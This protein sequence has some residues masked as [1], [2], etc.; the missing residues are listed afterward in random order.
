MVRKPASRYVTIKKKPAKKKTERQPGWFWSPALSA[1]GGLAGGAVGAYVGGPT[2]AS[3]GG[4][5]GK[6][7]GSAAGSKVAQLVGFGDYQ[8]RYPIVHNTILYNTGPQF[9]DRRDSMAGSVR[10]RH[11][12]FIADVVSSPNP[13]TFQLTS[14]PIV[15]SLATSFPWLSQISNAFEEFRFHGLVFEYVTSSGS[16]SST[17][18]LGTV[19]G[20]CRYNS[21]SAPYSNKQQMEASLFAQSTVASCS[22]IWPVECDMNQSPS[23][24]LLYNKRQGQTIGG[25]PRWNELGVFDLA[26]I[27]MPN[28]SETVG[29]LYVTYDV[30]CYKPFLVQ[31]TASQADHWVSTTGLASATPLG[32]SGALTSQSD[33]FT[34]IDFATQMLSFDP[35]FFGK[36]AVIY[37]LRGAAGSAVDPVMTVVQGCTAVNLIDLGAN[38]QYAKTYNTF[39][40]N[41]QSVGYFQISPVGGVRPQ[42]SFTGATLVGAVVMDLIVVQLPED[43]N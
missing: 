42:I 19:I 36:V 21:L 35:S 12:E 33:G 2:G 17:G 26:T 6:M 40:Q 37:N 32:T 25:D 43:L 4:A 1:V 34:D 18:Q 22:M 3:I 13:N 38:Y 27:G 9:M 5:A 24:G 15:P 31:D 8:V 28:A 20:A 11:R 7:L 29:E 39:E 10:I 23:R 14:Y 41:M 16:I 30:T